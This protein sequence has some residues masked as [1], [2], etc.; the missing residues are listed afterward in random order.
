MS[1]TMV[2]TRDLVP[3]QRLFLFELEGAPKVLVSEPSGIFFSATRFL[4]EVPEDAL[5][6]D[7]SLHHV[8]TEMVVGIAGLDANADPKR[9]RLEH[10]SDVLMLARPPKGREPLL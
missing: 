10:N 1:V 8:V 3:G 7:G 9:G 6:S 5:A 4:A 2:N